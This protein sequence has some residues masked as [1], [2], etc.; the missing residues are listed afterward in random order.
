MYQQIVG[1]PQPLW[2]PACRKVQQYGN[3]QNLLS[4][5]WF[6]IS[7]QKLSGGCIFFLGSAPHPRGTYLP[8]DYSAPSTCLLV[9]AQVD[10]PP[11][12]FV[13]KLPCMHAQSCPTL[14]NPTDCTLPGSSVHRILQARILEWFA[15]SFSRG[16]SPPRDRTQVS[17]IGR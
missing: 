3:L 5:L 8:R 14:C 15:I 9:Q 4:V 7:V 1:K 10:Y 6:K 17:C 13:F 16:S 12:I 2:I 11:G